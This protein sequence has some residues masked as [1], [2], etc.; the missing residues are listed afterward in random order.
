MP[1]IPSDAST[2][3][4]V[5]PAR[6][7]A[8]SQPASPDTVGAKLA[9][10]FFA[11]F[12]R[13]LLPTLSIAQWLVPVWVL[14]VPFPLWSD[15]GMAAHV[16]GPLCF[17]VS[18]LVFFRFS[19]RIDKFSLVPRFLLRLYFAF[20]L[21]SL[22]CFV[23]LVLCGL[24]WGGASLLLGAVAGGLAVLDMRLTLQPTLT[25]GMQIVAGLGVV[26]LVLLFAYGYVAGQRRLQISRMEL[27]LARWPRSGPR[28]RIAHISDLHIGTNL[29][30]RELDA[31]VQRVNALDPDLIVVTGD[32]L[33]SNPADIPV[34]FPRLKALRARLGVFACLGNH[35]RFAGPGRVA[36]GL[37][38]HT[39]IR[40][41]RDEVVHLP[42]GTT[43]LHVIGLRDR[44]RDWARGL[45]ADAVLGRLRR[46]LPDDEPCI[47][48]SHRPNIF[49]A[50]AA[51]HVDLTLS[52]HTHGGQLALPFW[53]QRLNIARFITR[54]PRGRYVIGTSLLYVN[55]GLGVSAERIRLFCPREIALM[56]CSAGKPAPARAPNPAS[57]GLVA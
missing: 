46:T 7:L 55:R 2:A 18:N 20:A 39:D 38:E 34:F 36:A 41:L 31:S 3:S 1:D 57:P 24:A 51:L 10:L 53:P 29:T 54:F 30:A 26:G 23:W 5:P 17:F 44:G 13:L 33:D 50:A 47:L 45:H 35:D 42:L 28:L 21:T 37:A 49:P 9:R 15:P 19:R 11:N 8:T 32:I 12:F 14:T 16:V 56:T 22:F 27:P 40:L 48:L 25:V 4:A 6:T 43:T 52:G